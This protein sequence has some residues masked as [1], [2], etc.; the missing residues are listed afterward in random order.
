MTE[1]QQ[2]QVISREISTEIMK[3]LI[4]RCGIKPD[5]AAERRLQEGGIVTLSEL[6]NS[7]IPVSTRVGVQFYACQDLFQAFIAFVQ[8]QLE[9][10]IQVAS[11]IRLQIANPRLSNFGLPNYA[12]DG[13]A[14]IDL[15][16]MLDTGA[17][18]SLTIAPNERVLIKTG[19]R[20]AM[21]PGICMIIIPRSG[22]GHKHGMIMGNSLGLIDS[23]YRGEVMVSCWNT[24][25][26]A[27]TINDG[28]R[29]AQA[30][31]LHTVKANFQVEDV[32][33]DTARGE[34]AFGHTGQQ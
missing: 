30:L 20:L 24:G 9:G 25:Q 28:D 21:P 34:G 32:L 31:F 23:D 12:T 1:T 33:D 29:I 3:N 14:A 6:G 13:A 8:Q 22:L 16:A 4:E 17:D 11:S 10:Q 2:N 19:L 15:R 7:V 18:T 26:T 27:F 5:V